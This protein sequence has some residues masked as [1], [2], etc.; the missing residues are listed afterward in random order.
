M[1][2]TFAHGLLALGLLA[3][4]F[5]AGVFC[6]PELR[7][8]A[9]TPE[10]LVLPQGRGAPPPQPSPTAPGP[11]NGGLE[12]PRPTDASPLVY[13]GDSGQSA[14]ADGLIAVTGSYGVGTSVL[15]VL[16]AKSR[17]L[18]VYEARGGSPSSRRLVFV[19]ARRIDLDLQL[20]AYNDDSDYQYR[21]LARRFEQ[22]G[23]RGAADA[24]DGAAAA[25]ASA[26]GG[27]TSPG[28]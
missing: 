10:D 14:S 12:V 19:G 13:G 18:A 5:G 3:T 16:D 21:D 6:A 28:K 4:A 8:L 17:Q 26:T 9:A 22:R 20:E 24:T 11:G 15:Y 7:R 1:T 25:P 27:E 2:A 23:R